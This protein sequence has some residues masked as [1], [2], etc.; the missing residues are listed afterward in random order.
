MSAVWEEAK[1]KGDIGE[2]LFKL[3][4]P[5]AKDVSNLREYQLIDV[6]F[7]LGEHLI[8]VKYDSVIHRTG[9]MFVED[10]TTIFNGN[11]HDGWYRI[12]GADTLCYI[13]AEDDSAHFISMDTLRSYIEK[14]K[15]A[16]A[17]C[18]PNNGNTIVGWL[19]PIARIPHKTIKL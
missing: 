10:Y 16:R 12:T 6:D 2:S 19:V 1:A 18:R 5:N 13:D 8:E 14:R 11:V 7:I 9:N 17:T 4:F 3:R 15:P